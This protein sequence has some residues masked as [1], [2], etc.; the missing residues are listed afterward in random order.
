MFIIFKIEFHHLKKN[1]IYMLC[2]FKRLWN[3]AERQGSKDNIVCL[4]KNFPW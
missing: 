4:K 1:Q 2:T 3:N